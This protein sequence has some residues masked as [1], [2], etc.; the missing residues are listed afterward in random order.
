MVAIM[1]P[2]IIT[3]LLDNDL[4]KFTMMQAVLHQYPAANV[5]YQF[6]CRK[7]TALSPYL[8]EIKAEIMALCQTRFTEDELAYLA[9]LPYI[10][11]DFIDF[12]RL[13]QLNS[14]FIDINVQKT[15]LQLT[16]TGPWLHTILFEVPILAIIS[17]VYF[18][19]TAPTPD[20][21]RARTTLQAK[22]DLIKAYDYQNT[23]RLTEF[24]TRR[25]FSKKWQEIVITELKRQIP[26]CFPGTSNVLFAKNLN[27]IPFGT[28][29]HEYLQA[30]QA[31]GPRLIDSQKQA[32]E[33][34]VKEYR[35]DLGI[36][37]TDV[38]GM[39]AFLRDF[40][41]YFAKLFDGIRHDSGDPLKWAH[42][43][44]EHYQQ[45]RIDPKTKKFIFSDALSIER[46]LAIHRALHKKTQVAFGVGTQL[47]NDLGYRSLDMVI[48]M[49]GC[50][51]QPVAKISDSPEKLICPNEIYLSYLKKVFSI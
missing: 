13:F 37:L 4:Y 39:Q 8:D 18:R 46:S 32:L 41:L 31:L 16:I 33:S 44:L 2:P 42:M 30:H 26:H 6:T 15:K 17:E 5:T 21:K 38:I 10:K 24:G 47:T 14:K 34:W 23:Y 9:S 12:L 36:A 22:I 45:L 50:N 3:S 11:S 20:F 25:R 51:G 35:G 27:L 19:N 48:K 40:D 28:M 7:P 29:A 49:I 1:K 43:A